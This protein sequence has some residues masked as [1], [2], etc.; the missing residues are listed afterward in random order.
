MM[1]KEQFKKFFIEDNLIIIVDGVAITLIL[2]A[3][4]IIGLS[5]PASSYTKEVE[6]VTMI[7]QNYEEAFLL[8][9]NEG[10]Y[11]PENPFF[12][13]DPYDMSPLS[14]LLMFETDLPTS[15]K[16][17]VLGKTSEGNMEFTSPETTTHRIP[18]YGLYAGHFNTIKLYQVTSLL[19]SQA[20]Y[21]ETLVSEI[22]V[23]TDPTPEGIFTPTVM[24]TTYEY[25]GS[26]L[27]MLMPALG[28]L[29]VAYDYNG[30]VRWYLSTSLT[31]APTILENGRLLLGTSRIINAPYY[32][33]GLYEIDFLGKIYT[34]YILPGGYHHDVFEMSNGNLLIGTSDFESTV[35]DII[36]ELDR[37]TG[38]IVKTW[39][40]GDYLPELDGMA[41]MWVTYDWFHN[42]SIFYDETTDSII[43][44]GRHQD[45]VISIDYT[46][47]ELNWIIGD[48]T[49]W[50]EE[51]VD[52]YFFYPI[53]AEF[54]WSYA[55]HSAIVLENGDI[56][57]FDNG[58]NRSKLR[59]DDILAEDNYSR[60]VI[61]RYNMISMTIE[62]VYQFGKELG[63]DFYSPY[64]S[65]VAYY[66]ENN[67]MIHSGGH[68][69]VNGEVLNIPAPLSEDFLSAKLNSITIEV[70]DGKIVYHL[71][72]P[73]NFYRANRIS[74]YSNN[75]IFSLGPATTLGNF[76][77][78]EDTED[79][80][81]ERHNFFVTVP[82]EYELELTKET[83]R[84]VINAVFN[85]HE[86]VYLV[87]EGSNG[88]I[89]YN[90]PTG[91]NTYTAMCI[92]IADGDNRIVSYYINEEGIIGTYQIYLY[93]NGKE[94]DTYE[95]VV[96][97]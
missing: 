39:D 93:V 7:Q 81:D 91:S 17:V 60:G 48:P 12:I 1:N 3:F 95:K 31:W 70:L 75:T 96:F 40:I 9:Y 65:N 37:T 66:S 24:N 11:T 21:P 56:F 51:L 27:M 14:G 53:S 47:D 78:T 88:R 76:I 38:E 30:D 20:P 71:E 50:S 54:E 74:L 26:D 10:N 34:E 8:E 29:P 4:L 55:Q 61:Y 67:Y 18:V 68:S 42:N 57:L 35:E 23:L 25:F 22:N 92:V 69:E 6:S 72:V 87:L 33:T 13:V 79:D 85:E 16:V 15:Y 2:I 77:V 46:T 84:L 49:N 58:N 28:S 90:I 52:E 5:A 94:Y 80:I 59:E 41:E 73:S 63:E 64:I 44:S 97:K 36:V 43:L 83:D 82:K 62:Q 86:V 45:A 89:V 19:S 32:T